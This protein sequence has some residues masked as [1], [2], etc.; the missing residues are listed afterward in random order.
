MLAPFSDQAQVFSIEG[1]AWQ[2]E[3]G[4]PG[5]RITDSQLYGG[6]QALS[7]DIPSAGGPLRLAGDYVYGDHRMPYA[8]AGLWGILRVMAPGT[9]SPLL[10]LTAAG[11]CRLALTRSPRP[12]PGQAE[13]GTSA[14]PD[15]GSS[16]GT[17]MSPRS[18]PPSGPRSA[19]QTP[20]PPAR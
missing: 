7:L 9:P 8:E 16:D 17:T 18:R 4:M 5:S 3:P 13:T 20:T 12:P 19:N 1:H 2:S 14:D 15:S 6:L 11:R 10:P